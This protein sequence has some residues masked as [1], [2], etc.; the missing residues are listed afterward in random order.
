MAGIK[1]FGFQEAIKN[2]GT[3]S[4]LVRIEALEAAQKAAAGYM[5]THINAAAPVGTVSRPASGKRPAHKAGQLK[6]SVGI[7]ERR[8]DRTSLEYSVPGLMVGPNKPK[9]YYGYWQQEGWIPTNVRRARKATA[10]SHSQSGANLQGRGKVTPHPNWF[11]NVCDA[12]SI[13]A[14]KAGVN[15]FNQKVREILSRTGM[16]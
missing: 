15:A 7:I 12:C 16:G 9:G 14:E 6:A 4:N 11:R 3:I 2:I 10:T 5:K 8:Q 1:A 13:G